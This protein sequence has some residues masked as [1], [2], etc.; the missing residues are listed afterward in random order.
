MHLLRAMT[1]L[2][3][4]ALFGWALGGCAGTGAGGKMITIHP[5]ERALPEGARKLLLGLKPC[6]HI[7]LRSQTQLEGE[8]RITAEFR[9]NGRLKAFTSDSELPATF[10]AC[11]RDR[12][13]RWSLP[14]GTSGRTL[15]P[16]TV[17]FKPV[18][19]TARAT[20]QTPPKRR[21]GFT[22]TLIWPEAMP[23]AT[24]SGDNSVGGRIQRV[25]RQRVANL[26]Y[27]YNR[28]LIRR[29]GYRAAARV[30][31]TINPLGLPYLVRV[32]PAT[33]GSLNQ[34][35]ISCLKQ[36]VVEW[37]FFRLPVDVR[38]GPFTIRFARRANPPK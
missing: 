27:C 8:L 7:A 35:M 29:P 24:R 33:P 30:S 18:G 5:G 28:E 22:D 3:G 19:D 12:I 31:F 2:L 21:P 16:L 25:I 20:A 9:E 26:R 10:K 17:S 36:K 23:T 13:A 38:Y 34:P 11:L 6:Y 4:F 1:G 37:H 15:G 32:K 14:P